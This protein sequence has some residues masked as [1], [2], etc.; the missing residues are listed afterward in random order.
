MPDACTPTTVT[1]G[2]KR[3]GQKTYKLTQTSYL[4]KVNDFMLL[5]VCRRDSLRVIQLSQCQHLA[6]LGVLL[7][8]QLHS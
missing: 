4:L 2:I 6:P 5:W 8:F 7:S 1:V 3:L